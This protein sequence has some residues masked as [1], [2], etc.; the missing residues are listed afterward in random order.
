MWI[1]ALSQKLRF[2]H[3]GRLSTEDLFDLKL[4]ELDEIYRNLKMQLDEYEHYSEDSL[5]DNDGEKDETYDELVLKMDV[6]R[7]V[8][9]HLKKQQE[10]LQRKIALQ[11][12]R[13]KILGIIADK[14]DEE[15]TN[16]SISELKEIL[17]DM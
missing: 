16:K 1:E 5:M 4:N 9:N 7:E 15:L 2:E 14:E 13:D 10:E 12:K 17:D 6:V 3:N 11:N 8:F